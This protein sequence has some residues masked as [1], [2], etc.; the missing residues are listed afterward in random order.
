MTPSVELLPPI[1]DA[2]VEPFPFPILLDEAGFA[3]I[4]DGFRPG[5]FQHLPLC[6][7]A[8]LG[9]APIPEFNKALIAIW[10]GNPFAPTGEALALLM[11]RRGLRGLIAGLQSIEAQMEGM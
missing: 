9:W 7:G 3:W 4:P 2:P 8:A 11:S 10:G 6:E 1:E 5:L